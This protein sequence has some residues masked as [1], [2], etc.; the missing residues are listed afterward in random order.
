MERVP[1]DEEREERISN[2]IIVDAYG[3]EEQAIGWY[4]YLE[5]TLRFPFRARCI[6]ERLTSPLRAGDK[7][8]VTEMAPVEECD[9]EMFVLVRW[10]RRT[11]AVPLAQVEGVAVE[12][13]TRQAIGD[14][15]YWIGR[16]H[17]L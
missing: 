11:L 15:H 7:V 13:E 12:E 5:E 3:P 16:G 6:A 9:H 17:Q 8:E 1:H 14:W 10:N 2:E 4:T